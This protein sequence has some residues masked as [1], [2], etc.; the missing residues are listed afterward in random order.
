MLDEII[1]LVEECE[2]FKG[3]GKS[4]FSEEQMEMS[5]YAK[6]RALVKEY[7]NGTDCKRDNPYG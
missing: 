5:T 4:R 6:I 7:K 3:H 1:R 2:D